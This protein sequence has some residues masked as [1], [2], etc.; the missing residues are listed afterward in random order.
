VL[1]FK[2][3]A[4]GPKSVNTSVYISDLVIIKY[5]GNNIIEIRRIV[6]TYPHLL[7]SALVVELELI[8]VYRTLV[9]HVLWKIC[10]VR[11]V[12][13]ASW[14]REFCSPLFCSVMRVPLY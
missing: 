4:P 7:P 5:F 1:K 13:M 8:H 2:C 9:I 11:P 12:S 10:D 6:F 3:P 14:N